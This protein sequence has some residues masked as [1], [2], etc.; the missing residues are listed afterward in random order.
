MEIDL[1]DVHVDAD[2][3]NRNPVAQAIRLV[4]VFAAH[5]VCGFDEAIIIVGHGRHVDQPLD[6]VLDELDKQPERGDAGDVPL[7]FIA[8]LVGHEPHL[9]PLQ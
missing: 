5:H 3:L 2:H 8:D 9:L 6:E 1:P 4:R 7:E